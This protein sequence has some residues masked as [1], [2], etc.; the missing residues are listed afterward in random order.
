VLFLFFIIGFFLYLYR[1]VLVSISNGSKHTITNIVLS[2]AN[3]IVDMKN[4][5]QYRA[6]DIRIRPRR[7]TNIELEYKI[8][9]IGCFKV[10]LDVY[11]SNSM[12]GKSDIIILDNGD[13]DYRDRIYLTAFDSLRFLTSWRH[14]I[15]NSKKISCLD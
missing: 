13:I 10:D 12:V 6:I 9:N 5:E 8:D 3:Q 4:V 2:Y 14:K 11:I 7:E 1:G 15:V